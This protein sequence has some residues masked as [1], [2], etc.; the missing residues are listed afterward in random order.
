MEAR[1]HNLLEEAEK[2]AKNNIKSQSA[3]KEIQNVDI[4]PATQYLL[5]D[6]KDT[7]VY[8]TVQNYKD[9]SMNVC[10]DSTY[11]FLDKVTYRIVFNL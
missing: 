2:T 5:T 3:N 1:Y 7:S 9:N 6:P 10:M 4:G 8:M 11:A